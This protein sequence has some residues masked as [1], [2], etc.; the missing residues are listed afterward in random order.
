MTMMVSEFIM[1]ESLA[2]VICVVL[3]IMPPLLFRFIDSKAL[4]TLFS[5]SASR[6]LVA[7]SSSKIAGLFSKV[8]AMATLCFCPPESWQ[9]FS[10]TTVSYPLGKV[11][12]NSCMFAC[13][14]TSTISVSAAPSLP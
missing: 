4:T 3:D 13:L 5:D 1:V 7:S 12:I 8:L 11:L 2:T 10:P 9:P 14:D 6:A